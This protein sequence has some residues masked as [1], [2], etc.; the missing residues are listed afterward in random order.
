MTQ[1][2]STEHISWPIIKLYATWGDM[3]DL[4]VHHRDCMFKFPKR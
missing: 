1:K 3:E 2:G 4:D